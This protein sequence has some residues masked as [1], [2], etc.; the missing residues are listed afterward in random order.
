MG[1]NSSFKGL[2]ETPAIAQ[3]HLICPGFKKSG[4][5]LA[6]G[7]RVAHLVRRVGLMQ[8]LEASAFR[9]QAR[10]VPYLRV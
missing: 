10:S 2:T 3:K 1:F 4:R 9:T 6:F 8:P 5:H 7:A